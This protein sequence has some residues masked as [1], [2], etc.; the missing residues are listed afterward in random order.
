MTRLRVGAVQLSSGADRDANL[1]TISRLVD[2]AA[3]QGC[4]L[5][6]LPEVANLR[7]E[8]VT[9][10]HGE[11]IPGPSTDFLAECARRHRIWV[12]AGSLLESAPEAAPRLFNTSV[13][14]DPDGEI[15]AT[16]R[17]IH[18]FD[19]DVGDS[20]F[21]ESDHVAR[22]DDV[23]MARVNDVDVGLSICY[24]LRFPELYRRLAER[25]AR[26][27][28]IP[29]AFT[30][31]TGRAH[32]DVLVRARAIENQAFVVAPAQ[33]GGPG[34]LSP[35]YGHSL[36]VDPWGVVLAEAHNEQTV[37]AADLDFEALERV[38]AEFPSLAHRRLDQ[39]LAH[40]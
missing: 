29:A 28:F 25:G 6:A 39:P 30:E 32:W 10:A 21:R 2:Q 1:T 19:V 36:I 13:L 3:A 38:R 8:P 5:V 7:A 16:Y 33:L 22:G 35:C 4:Q 31:V 26:L 18:L 34:G 40:V 17:K 23:V 9:L 20:R 14:I 24:D 27:M 11:P 15:T 37:V 12:H